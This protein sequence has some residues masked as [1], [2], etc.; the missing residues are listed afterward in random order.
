MVTSQQLFG[1]PESQL[2]PSMK[3]FLYNYNNPPASAAP[4]AVL[5]SSSVPG[6]PK[7][8]AI[9]KV[10]EKTKPVSVSSSSYVAPVTTAK[11]RVIV[12]E[13]TETSSVKKFLE[14]TKKTDTS[15]YVGVVQYG[16]NEPVYDKPTA[17]D[18][19]AELETKEE[20]N[21][22]IY[23]DFAKVGIQKE[24]GITEKQISTLK[25]M[26]YTIAPSGKENE[27][28]IVPPEKITE[29]YNELY[30]KKF[31][32]GFKQASATEQ[33]KLMKKYY[34]FED[35][36]WDEYQQ[37][38]PEV[39]IQVRDNKPMVVDPETD[40][41]RL[42]EVMGKQYENMPREAAVA[43][44]LTV[45]I[46][47]LFRPETWLTGGN[48]LTG[49]AAKKA[50]TE[51]IKWEYDLS[52]LSG[53]EK[54]VSFQVPAYENVIIP[55]TLGGIFRFAG[56]AAE[57]ATG[58]LKSIY[59]GTKIVGGG[60]VAVG[61]GSDIGYTGATNPSK[62]PS[63]L[64]TTGFQFG[65]MGVGYRSRWFTQ[66]EI[67]AMKDF[68]A[69]LRPKDYS[70]F[71]RDNPSIQ[72]RMGIGDDIYSRM[73]IDNK[74]RVLDWSKTDIGYTTKPKTFNIEGT[75]IIIS[76]KKPVRSNIEP[77]F[78]ESDMN[79]K[80]INKGKINYKVSDITGVE[81]IG[82]DS[83]TLRLIDNAKFK[84]KNTRNIFEWQKQKIGATY[85]LFGKGEIKPGGYSTK[86]LLK[87]GSIEGYSNLAKP[88]ER[89]FTMQDLSSDVPQAWRQEKLALDILGE[90][91]RIKALKALS[92]E[93]YNSNKFKDTFGV[94][95]FIR[96]TEASSKIKPPHPFDE[97]SQ[98]YRKGKSPLDVEQEYISSH[99]DTS[100][101]KGPHTIQD[102]ERSLR[103][104]DL[105]R[106]YEK[107]RSNLG[108]EKY[109]NEKSLRELSDMQLGKLGYL[110]EIMSMQNLSL[111]ETQGTRSLNIQF[112]DIN[113][114]QEQ[115]SSKMTVQLQSQNQLQKQ[116]TKQL[117]SLETKTKYNEIYDLSLKGKTK[118]PRFDIPNIPNIKT[119]RFYFP[120][121]HS[122]KTMKTLKNFKTSGTGYR[123]RKWKVPTLEQL[124]GLKTGW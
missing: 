98:I 48:I 19:R 26:G 12:T 91:N 113:Q 28:S 39:D 97:L 99:W 116:I 112:Q 47:A 4:A 8:S 64:L 43:R 117:L 111:G 31:E 16:P 9:A 27:I 34:L 82:L 73:L 102:I 57:G 20:Y 68:G 15:P 103:G 56:P 80:L 50:L 119:S 3:Q 104:E 35:K 59:T 66:S 123:Y 24:Q 25:S 94:N 87:I 122:K 29:Y 40:I 55:L 42:Y 84:L 92:I 101:P 83:E 33:V 36:S 70:G 41:K 58:F 11:E 120:N 77:M 89:F 61:I 22:L 18:I 75:D 95:E 14:E 13:F 17:I 32:K 124:I 69:R 10:V 23:S 108:K 90:P 45:A 100:K 30:Q 60:A 76:S 2:T 67:L 1:I 54:W 37:L 110:G 106:Y 107:N 96:N 88:K 71:I 21:K 6:V 118:K 53:A 115:Q 81:K 7:N 44:A 93:G 86:E 62:L 46:G 78:K 51:T 49:S 105:S 114:I 65:L 63:N 72:S 109:W 5:P 52:K 121:I 85:D 79:I 74:P 38:H